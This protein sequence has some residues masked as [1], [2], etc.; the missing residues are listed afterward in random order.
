MKLKDLR[1]QTKDWNGDR[2]I[3]MDTQTKC[4]SCKKGLSVRSY[5][6]KLYPNRYGDLVLLGNTI[7]SSG[8]AKK[9]VKIRGEQPTE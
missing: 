3:L 2:P 6:S 5:V 1:E 7:P 8:V 4:P 9:D